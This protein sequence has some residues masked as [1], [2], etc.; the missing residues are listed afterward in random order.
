[1]MRILAARFVVRLSGM[2]D[3][4]IGSTRSLFYGAKF[5]AIGL[6]DFQSEATD[7]SAL[8]V[9]LQMLCE[10]REQAGDPFGC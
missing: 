3:P 7:S 6:I 2:S 8:E 9:A 1:M 10:L 4:V 5:V